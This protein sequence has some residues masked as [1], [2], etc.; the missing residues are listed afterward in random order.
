MGINIPRGKRI[1][2][3]APVFTMLISVFKRSSLWW[4]CFRVEAQLQ[5]LQSEH[6][7]GEEM[8]LNLPR[9]AYLELQVIARSL[10]RHKCWAGNVF[11]LF[12]LCAWQTLSPSPFSLEL[13]QMP[14]LCS[15]SI[16]YTT[17]VNMFISVCGLRYP[18]WKLMKTLKQVPI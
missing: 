10:F 12:L 3:W 5:V 14:V 2:H 15:R 8:S 17:Y 1:N 6:R 16:T 4:H 18:K 9:D 11:L 7:S 13:F